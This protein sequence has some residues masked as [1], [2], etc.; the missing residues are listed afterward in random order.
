MVSA[1]A[2]IPPPATRCDTHWRTWWYLWYNKEENKHKPSIFSSTVL[3]EAAL[4][5]WLLSFSCSLKSG[6]IFIKRSDCLVPSL[7]CLVGCFLKPKN[8][9]IS[10]QHRHVNAKTR[11]W[12]NQY[13]R[14][15]YSRRIHNLLYGKHY[16]DGRSCRVFGGT[17]SFFAGF[18]VLIAGFSCFTSSSKSIVLHEIH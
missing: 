17:F 16:L 5:A 12:L 13:D 8:E 4:N 18:G 2:R 3:S 11:Q 7:D 10:A 14:R 9:L 6:V 15:P 1:Q